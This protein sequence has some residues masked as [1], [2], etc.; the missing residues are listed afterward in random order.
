VE[1]KKSNVVV[2]VFYREKERAELKGKVVMTQMSD[3]Q[4]TVIIKMMTFALES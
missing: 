4:S 3:Q 1:T 2:A